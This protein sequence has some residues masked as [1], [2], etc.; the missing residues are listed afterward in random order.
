M[1]KNKKHEFDEY[2]KM[3]NDK[4]QYIL[5]GAGNLGREFFDKFSDK[6]NII[7]FC[8]SD[9]TKIGETFCG[10]VVNGLED[11][12][13]CKI[14][15]TSRYYAEIKEMLLLKGLEEDV[16]F[17]YEQQF[18]AVFSFYKYHK[19]VF[20]EFDISITSHCTLNCEYCNMQMHKFSPK[21]FFPMDDIKQEVDIYFKW[22]DYVQYLG[23]MGG[24]PFLHPQL[25]DILRYIAENYRERM[26][27]L[28]VLTNGTCTPTEKFWELCEEYNISIQLSDYSSGLP[29]LR[30]KVDKLIGQT[31]QRHIPCN[32]L[33]YDNWLDFGLGQDLNEDEEQLKRKF[34][35]CNNFWRSVYQ[36]K[37]YY[38][39]L[40]TSA[41]RAGITDVVKEDV[42][43]LLDYSD[44]RKIELLEYDL[45]RNDKGYLSF[46]RS[47]R[48]CSAVND[49]YVVPAVQLTREK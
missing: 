7:G 28:E 19:L 47:C 18:E 44:T 34:A 45:K 40:Q 24:E 3:W 10:K 48:G 37:Y 23:I 42:F 14:I 15:V 22:V 33:R 36:D 43:D 1:W 4:H 25:C 32:V 35:S 12:E 29:D 49:K 26:A 39:H 13:D 16:D 9:K 2:A 46:C 5:Y 30:E 41:Y 8:D 20:R 31:G 27:K 17:T 21:K 6:I 38:C 11:F